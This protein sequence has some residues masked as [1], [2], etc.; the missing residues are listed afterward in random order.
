M[1]PCSGFENCW[2]PCSRARLLS[3]NSF[4]SNHREAMTAMEWDY[5]PSRAQW[6]TARLRR[7]QTFAPRLGTGRFNPKPV[8]PQR[9][10]FGVR[11]LARNAEPRPFR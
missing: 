9:E 10:D 2:L 4:A 7:F 1:R 11:D 3:D 8:L 6:Q 5:R